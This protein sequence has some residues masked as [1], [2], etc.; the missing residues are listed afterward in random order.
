MYQEKAKILWNNRVGNQ[1]YKIGLTC[2]NGYSDATPGQFI[3]LHFPG[4]M[5]PF[6][7]RPFSIHSIINTGGRAAGIELLYKVVG[8]G[9]KMLSEHGKGEV[10]N[11]LGP[12]GNGFMFSNH[13]KRIFIVAGG[14]GVAPMFFLASYLQTKGTDPFECMV[15][16]GGRSKDDL[17]CADDFLRMGMKIHVTT[18]DGS[19]GDQCFITHPLETALE[20]D[21]PDIIYACG[22]LDM[23]KCVAGIAEKHTVPCQ[24]SMETV[25]ACGMGACL[26]CAVEGKA[27]SGNYMHVCSDGPVFDVRC[28][29]L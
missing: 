27:A 14:I 20:M 4:R 16:L 24:V 22:P 11:I 7:P 26:G 23:L 8:E 13:Y 25:M 19:A 29:K 9:T 17:L 18:D 10:V 12:L 1:Y 3:M 2:H 21:L 5:S 6:L 15:F 28:L